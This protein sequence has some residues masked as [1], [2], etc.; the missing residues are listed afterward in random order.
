MDKIRVPYIGFIIELWNHKSAL[1][2]IKFHA[3]IVLF[4][5]CEK[6]V[7]HKFVLSEAPSTDNL[8]CG[9]WQNMK[10]TRNMI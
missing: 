8:L 6:G 7:E 2:E 5:A 9:Y 1:L 10:L 4:S 3:K